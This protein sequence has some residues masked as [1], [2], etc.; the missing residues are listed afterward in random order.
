MSEHPRGIELRAVQPGWQAV[1]HHGDGTATKYWG[2]TRSRAKQ[3]AISGET[4]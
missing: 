2:A 1:V 4:Q 3:K